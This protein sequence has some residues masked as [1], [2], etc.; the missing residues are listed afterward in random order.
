MP[1]RNLAA[2][3]AGQCINP[4]L[5]S[6]LGG[7]GAFGWE[8]GTTPPDRTRLTRGGK[9]GGRM[10]DGMTQDQQSGDDAL[11]RLNSALEDA[12]ERMDRVLERFDQVLETEDDDGSRGV[13]HPS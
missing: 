2:L 8:G 13:R 11:R 5:A 10:T 1:L 9:Q 6:A 12:C 3:D 7:L 4:P